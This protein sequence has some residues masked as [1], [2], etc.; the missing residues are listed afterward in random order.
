[1]IRPL[2]AILL[3]LLPFGMQAQ[4]PVEYVQNLGQWDGAFDYRGKTAGG[5][6]FLNKGGYRVTLSAPHNAEKYHLKK[7]GELEKG[8]QFDFHNY[9]VDFVGSQK[10]GSFIGSKSQ[11]HYYNY[12][13]G[14]NPENWHSEIHPNLS[15]DYQNLYPNIDWHVFSEEGQVKYD[16]IVHPNG[17]VK[18]IVLNYEGIE[19]MSISKKGSL[20]L[21]TSLGVIQEL[22]PYAYQMTDEGRKEVSCKYKIK[23][24]QVHFIFPKGYDKSNTLYIDPVIV[25]CTFTAS[26]ADNWGFTAT[27]D[28]TGNFYA[29][30]I[31]N[32]LNPALLYPTTPGA[33]Q[34][35]YGGGTV[36]SNIPSDVTLT[37]FDPTGT[38]LVYSTYL[39]GSE[40][41]QPHSLICDD[42]GNLVVA[43]RTLSV[44]F[45]VSTGC[46]DNSHNGSWD[47]F[48]TKFNPGGTALLGSTYIGGTSDDCVNI[49]SVLTSL[50]SLKHNYGDDSRSEVILDA[51]GNIC[52]AACTRSS[53]FPTANNPLQTTLGGVQDGV[54]FEFDPTL[55]NLN[56]ST[57]IG[58]SGN[59]ACYVLNF[60]KNNPN[61]LFVAGGSESSDL[62]TTSGTIHSTYQGA[63]DGFVYK[64]DATTR[65]LL[66]GTY[67]GTSAYDQV[68][69]IQ[70]DDS[71]HVYITGLTLGAY[72][73]TPGVYSNPNSAQ[74][75]TKIDANLTTNLV[76]TVFGDG[77]NAEVDISP[78]AFLVD[79]CGN[80]YVSGWGGP[81]GGVLNPSSTFGLPTTANAFQATTDGG[82]FYF[83]VLDK[84]M[85][86][87]LFGSF[88]GQNNAASGDHVDGGTSRFD[89]NG[90]V[91]QSICAAC[92]ANTVPYPTTAGV[93][94]PT[95][96]GPNCNLAALKID[97]QLQ[98]PDADADAG[99]NNTGC[100]PF[101]VT[102]QNNSSSA[103]SY[104]WD[105]GD[106]SPVSS[107]QTPTHTYTTAGT[108][109]VRLIAENPGGCTFTS[110]TDFVTIT[111][112]DDSIAANFTYIKIDSCGPFSVNIT[113]TSTFNGGA[114]N[115]WTDFF[116]DFGDGTTFSGANPGIHLFPSANNFTVKLIMT[117]SLGCNSPDSISINVDFSVS[118]VTAAFD[119]PD[120]LCMPADVNFNDQSTNVTTYA[121]TF[122]D[123]GNS[124]AASP[125]HT[126]TS[127]GQYSIT[128][129]TE[130]L[131]TCNLRDTFTKDITVFPSPVADFYYTPNPPTPNKALQFFSTSTGANGYT[132]NFGDG[133]TSNL[134]NPVHLY[135]KDGLYDVCLEVVN[136]F[137]C[138]DSL[139][140]KVRGYVIP[141]VDVPSGFSP[142]GD[143]YNDVVRVLGY[144][145][146]TLDFKIFNRWGELV[147]QTTDRW[148]GW[149]GSYKGEGQEMDTFAYTLDVTFFDGSSTFKKGNI[150]LLR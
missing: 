70:T 149:D 71:S 102:F 129:I 47:M 28:S 65:N 57:Y 135:Q 21:Q 64:F 95:D 44:N 124:V 116:W 121:W 111:V 81:L 83:F 31:V 58:G 144:G 16:L 119:V 41:D 29:G 60:D 62:A 110:D 128:L 39:G 66:A 104:N 120:S 32:T 131:N 45:P 74:F 80:I 12:Y 17:D 30:G 141:L 133:E 146:E 40:D 43:G 38:A 26:A 3:L 140:Q 90:I 54:V 78:V 25:F 126:Y 9:F 20:Q 114:T 138:K 88:F 130:N 6:I 19:K 52:V 14:K 46:Y 145:I 42:A 105:F 8:E 101:Q 22:A 112:L 106:G 37:K 18:D 33:F 10:E 125:S 11:K 132:W 1:V 118:I 92:G 134:E 84:T 53:N 147:F 15:V 75:I 5:D 67:I 143:G 107:Q 117:D 139:C 150:T 103:T 87:F 115:P 35:I 36:G 113:N 55:S 69:G 82:D 123:G 85:Q 97:F 94:G 72:P 13:L 122:G 77:S 24:G 96:P 98:D 86:N 109:I 61:E 136:E 137:G 4:S 51:N 91:Y 79:R 34:I 63:I 27:Y 108:Y 89:P 76:S 49:T 99:L 73:T 142:N 93:Y 23:N 7:H 100:A 50:S 56:W 48:V 148:E 59:D 2:Y 127:P 68:F